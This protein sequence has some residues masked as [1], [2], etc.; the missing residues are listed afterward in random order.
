MFFQPG[1]KLPTTLK[2]NIK[3]I[4]EDESKTN[5]SLSLDVLCLYASFNTLF[6]FI[7]FY[8]SRSPFPK[9]K[10]KIWKYPPPSKW[11]QKGQV[12][13]EE[14]EDK[15][16]RSINKWNAMNGYWNHSSFRSEPRS[17]GSLFSRKMT[18]K[19][20]DASLVRLILYP[21]KLPLWATRIAFSGYMLISHEQSHWIPSESR[22]A[23]PNFKPQ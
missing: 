18:L 6:S 23:T 16:R 17:V 14:F 22:A 11:W 10:T 1:D 8:F 3:N 13:G 19:I 5:N 20:E 9:F 4:N 21:Q 12:E 7:S 15:Q 2:K